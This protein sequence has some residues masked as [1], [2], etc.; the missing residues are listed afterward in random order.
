MSEI[1]K[2]EVQKMYDAQKEITKEKDPFA[3]LNPETGNFFFKNEYERKMFLVG[4]EASK[5]DAAI[6][7]VT[8]DKV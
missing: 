2:V 3:A 7:A 1:G 4:L 5:V 6:R 8:E